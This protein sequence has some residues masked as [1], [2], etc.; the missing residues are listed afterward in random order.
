MDGTAVMRRDFKYSP[1]LYQ[2]IFGLNYPR[3]CRYDRHVIYKAAL[4]G[5]CLHENVPTICTCLFTA[6]SGLP[7]HSVSAYITEQ[8][9]VL[10]SLRMEIDFPELMAKKPAVL[11]GPQTH[12]FPFDDL[13]L[14][15]RINILN[16]CVEETREKL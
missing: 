7:H 12:W 2:V 8:S 9:L 11:T 4:R 13:G 5:M 3:Y 1:S 14:A 15:R 10:F 16:T 6:D